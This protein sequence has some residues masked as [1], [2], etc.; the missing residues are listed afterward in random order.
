MVIATRLLKLRGSGSVTEIPIR[1]YKPVSDADGVW[2][3]RFEINWPDE[4]EAMS[5]HGYDSIQ[6]MLLALQMV[7][8]RIYASEEHKSGMLYVDKPGRGYGF[9]VV[10]P[11]RGLLIG[12]DRDL[13]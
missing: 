9:P 2:S 12:D 1:L 4:P 11:E 5:I 7:G 10:G 6:A 3:C 13:F 8:S